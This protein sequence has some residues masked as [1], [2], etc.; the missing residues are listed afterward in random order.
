V[1]SGNLTQPDCRILSII[2][3]LLHEAF[4]QLIGYREVDG[5]CRDFGGQLAVSAPAFHVALPN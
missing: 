2:R 5:G 3:V 1:Y 4:G